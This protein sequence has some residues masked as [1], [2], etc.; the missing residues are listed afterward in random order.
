MQGNPNPAVIETD[1]GGTLLHN[2]GPG[3]SPP[4]PCTSSSAFVFW[5]LGLGG[6]HSPQMLPINL[7]MKPLGEAL[8]LSLL[9]SSL[10]NPSGSPLLADRKDAQL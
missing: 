5:S 8:A 7:R 4:P 3:P 1:R 2:G 10:R 6:S 9:A